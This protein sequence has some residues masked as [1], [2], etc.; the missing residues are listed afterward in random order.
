MQIN[1]C[2]G[3]DGSIEFDEPLLDSTKVRT[4]EDLLVQDGK[5]I[6]GTVMSVQEYL[7]ALRELHL[8]KM[9][10]ESVDT[11]LSIEFVI[12]TGLVLKIERRA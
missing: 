1:K 12:V 10:K 5:V 9:V 3:N 4:L 2:L 11:I 6:L 8:T 7:C